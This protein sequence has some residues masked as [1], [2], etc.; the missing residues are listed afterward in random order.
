MVLFEI[1]SVGKKPFSNLTNNEVVKK[2]NSGFCQPPPPGCP[3]PIY[4]LMINC[5]LDMYCKLYVCE[6][7]VNLF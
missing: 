2:L 4:Q 6:A 5:W 7:I 3:R 1:W